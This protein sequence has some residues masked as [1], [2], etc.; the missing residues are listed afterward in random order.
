MKT[1]IVFLARTLF[2]GVVA[3]FA[4]RSTSQTSKAAVGI[5]AQVAGPGQKNPVEKSS[6]GST[7]KDLEAMYTVQ[8]EAIKKCD[9]K[10]FISTL[11][12]DY[13]IK[14]L[15][16]DVFSRQQVEGFVESDM[17]RTKSVE[18]SLS[19]ID[20]LSAAKNEAVVIVTHEASRVLDDADGQPHKWENKVVHKETWI[21]TAE[22]WRI[23]RLEE[24]K[25]VYVLRDGKPLHP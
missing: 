24:L 16:G 3:V 19:S 6:P 25:Q 2:L 13:S 7:R 18:K 22:G 12:P 20:S 9:F 8:D 5:P 10:A 4:L 1:S 21:K 17:A 14:L 15:N 11:A 23:Q